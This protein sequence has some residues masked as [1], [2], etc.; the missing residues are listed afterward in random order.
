MGQVGIWMHVRDACPA[1]LTKNKSPQTKTPL[2]VVPER[3]LRWESCVMLN[4]KYH[5][6][7]D[8]MAILR[9][10]R[11]SLMRLLRTGKLAATRVGPGGGRVLITDEAVIA[12]VNSCK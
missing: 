9:L 10:S 8:V 11:T 7:E 3:F 5:T 12:Y 2:T 6:I 4:E 1:S